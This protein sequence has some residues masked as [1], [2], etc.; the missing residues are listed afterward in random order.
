MTKFG[1][2]LLIAA[3][4]FAQPSYTDL[5]NEIPYR[6]LGP[7][8]AGAWAIGVA[9]P[10][11]PA[12]AHAHTFYAAVRTGGVW[13]TTDNG[14]TFENITDSEGINSVGAIAVAPSDANIVWV[15]TGDNS[16]TRSAYYGNG[17]YKSADA[18]KTWKK[19]GLEDTQHFSRIVIDPA[20][21][22]IVY[23]AALGHLFSVNAERGVFKSTDGGRTWTKSLFRNDHTGAVD[24]VMD[25][26]NSKVLYAALY[27]GMRHPWHLDDGGPESGIYKTTD[28]GA[29]WNKLS[30]GLPSG[31]LGRIGIDICRT[32]PDTI[33]AVVDN[34]NTMNRPAGRGGRG[35]GPGAIGGQVY[36]T[37]DGGQSWRRTSAEGEDVSRKAGYSFNQIFVDPNDPERAFITGSNMISTRDGGKTWAG[38]GQYGRG[39]L[40]FRGTFGDFRSLWIDPLDSLHMI[41]TSDGGVSI[42]YDGGRTADHMFNIKAGEVYAIGVDNE[43]PY[44]LYAGL[45]DHENW[46]G[47]INGPSGRVGIEDWVTTGVGDGM[48]NVPDPAGRWLYNTQE[49]GK[50]ARV[51]MQEHTRTGHRAAQTA[52]TFPFCVTTGRRRS[53]FRRTT[54]R[55]STRARRCC[56]A[57]PIAAITGKSSAPT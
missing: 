2:L 35:G 38:L 44:N 52:R 55:S 28:G 19:M 31:P 36:R 21:P 12:I 37:D 11:N 43:Q 50:M 7:F 51:D 48:Y 10:T 53:A 16:I 54:R 46:K 25:P 22:D 33:Y 42:S 40:V 49:F 57:P 34:F 24:L 32:H 3:G 18:G 45:Q 9:V 1:A 47:P 13:K 4:A 26:R 27:D 15:G 17:I 8:R 41:A 14:V 5:L 56:S 30:A 6:N 29:T 39:D 20:N 23:A